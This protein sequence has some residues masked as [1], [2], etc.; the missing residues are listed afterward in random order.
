MMKNQGGTCLRQGVL[1]LYIVCFPLLFGSLPGRDY[2]VSLERKGTWAG[3]SI[4]R[5]L[6]FICLLSF[7][8][9]FIGMPR[10]RGRDSWE[11]TVGNEM[12]KTGVATFGR[13]GRCHGQ[14]EIPGAR[15]E[16][17]G[18]GRGQLVWLDFLLL[19][20]FKHYQRGS[21]FSYILRGDLPQGL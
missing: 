15:R 11:F 12:K 19:S 18:K 20:V 13:G 21:T 5:R 10:R 17:R 1:I 3:T 16:A 7:S 2:N 8:L 6:K 14:N 4:G 9:S